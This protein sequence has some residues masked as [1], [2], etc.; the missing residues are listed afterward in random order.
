MDKQE[1]PIENSP[2]NEKELEHFRNKLHEEKKRA[3]QTI[4]DLKETLGDLNEAELD[5]KSSLDDHQGNIATDELEKETMYTMIE[6]EKK[7]IEKIIVA[8]DR[9]ADGNYGICLAT[10]KPI[11]KERL[12]AIPYALYTVEAANE[13]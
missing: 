2:F 8:L 3:E 12:E 6:K 9:I 4:K 10:G 11:A 7:K 1:T 5:E 13:I